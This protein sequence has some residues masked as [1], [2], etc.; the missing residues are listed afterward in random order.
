MAVKNDIIEAHVSIPKDWVSFLE[1]EDGIVDKLE[2]LTQE[3]W[4]RI[5]SYAVGYCDFD[6][7]HVKEELRKLAE[8]E[9]E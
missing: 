8:S 7:G 5:L 4:N 6:N 3:Q 1:G 9:V 2:N